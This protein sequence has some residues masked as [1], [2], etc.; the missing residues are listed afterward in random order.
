MTSA[1]PLDGRIP[2]GIVGGGFMGRRHA[3]T[4]ARVPEFRLVGVADPFSSELADELGVRAYASHLAMLDDGVDAVIV[5]NPNDQHV[6]T[7]LDA[8]DRG[9]A[10]LVEKPLAT[11]REALDPLLVAAQAGSPILVGHHRR[12]H[13]VIAAAREIVA[14]GEI[15]DLVS[16]NGMWVSRKADAYFE[17]AW[18]RAPGAGVVLINAVHDLDLLRVLCGEFVSVHARTTSR[19]RG[20]DVPDTAVLDFETRDGALGTYVCS[21]AAVSPWSWDLGTSDEPAF[22]FNPLSSCYFLAGTRG[23]IT[24]PQLLVHHYDGEPSWNEPL[25]MRVPAVSGSDSYTRQLEHFARVVR[26]EQAPLVTVADAARTIAL[27]DAVLASAAAGEAVELT[28]PD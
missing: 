6:S 7:T 26:A 2:I 28:D 15:G 4:L 13:P 24:L 17:P 10:V 1:A 12:H 27:L 21:D 25:S 8:H 20:L 3:A 5:A 23:S 9:V 14:D 11:S 18:R 19:W 22:P 16:V